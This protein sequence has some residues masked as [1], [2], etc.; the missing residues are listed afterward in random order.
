M[1]IPYIIALIPFII[2]FLFVLGVTTIT[3][4]TL[5]LYKPELLLVFALFIALG[6]ASNSMM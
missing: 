3:T 1:R 6:L 4:V 5:L 2:I